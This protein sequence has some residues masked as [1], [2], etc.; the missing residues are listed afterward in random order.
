MVKFAIH[1]VGHLGHVKMLEKDKIL[2]EFEEPVQAVTPTYRYY[3]LEIMLPEVEQLS[4]N[5]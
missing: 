4:S 1:I 2:V 5:L 3:I